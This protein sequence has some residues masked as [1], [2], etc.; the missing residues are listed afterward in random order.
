[1]LSPVFFRDLGERGSFGSVFDLRRVI[2]VAAVAFGC[3]P[4]SSVPPAGG[5]DDSS[6]GSDESATTVAP[7]ETPPPVDPDD[8]GL[9]TDGGSGGPAA[10]PGFIMNPDGGG[11]SHQCSLWDQDCPPG[12]KCNV[13][14]NDGGGAWNATKCVPIVDDPGEPGDPCTVEGSAVSGI[15]TCEEG[16]MCWDVVV[17]TNEGT[18]VSYCMGSENNPVCADPDQI[19]S[20][21]REFAL[22]LPLCCPLEQD[23]P[24]EQDACIPVNDGFLCTYDASGDLGA[25]AD[26]C[27]YVND[28]DPGLACLDG[29]RVPG[30]DH[31]GCCTSFCGVG[32]ASCQLLDDAMD[33]IPWYDDG[34]AP[35]G[36]EDVGVCLLPE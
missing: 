27:E 32:S 4:V 26:P 11:V 12:Q 33:C 18:C 5:H 10:P 19:C 6:S 16:A 28:C 24:R 29:E 13:W 9:E 8:D 30:C 14:A 34:E 36:F 23:C 17:E 21:G 2:A 31:Y 20:G 22:C 25:F 15:D 7:P 1:M 35:H 3:G